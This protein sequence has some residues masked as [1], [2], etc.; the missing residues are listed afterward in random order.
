[1]F[2]PSRRKVRDSIGVSIRLIR[3]VS[4]NH[5]TVST[6]LGERLTQYDLMTLFNE[7]SGRECIPFKVSRCETLV[8]LQVSKIVCSPKREESEKERRLTMSKMMTC[9]FVWNSFSSSFHWSC[10]GSIP[11]GFCAQ[12]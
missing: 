5:D 3:P 6:D 1:M 11:V 2:L 12:A 4:C 10:V 8:R 9:F 7:I